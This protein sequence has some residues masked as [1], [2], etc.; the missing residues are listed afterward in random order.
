MAKN[1]IKVTF[2]GGLKVNAEVRGMIITT[3]Q[4]PYAGGEGSAPAP[5]DLFLASIATCAGYYVLAFCRQRNLP[6]DGIYLTMSMETGASK[7]I[8]KS[9]IVIHLPASFPE[10]YLEA[11]V[12]AA[13]QCAVKAHILH[14]PQFEVKAIKG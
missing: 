4:P 7:M 2:P 13:D 9:E 12:R 6:T 14:P 11:V 3:D 8:E 5:F 10:K 1:E